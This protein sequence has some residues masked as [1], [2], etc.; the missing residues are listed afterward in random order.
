MERPIEKGLNLSRNIDR[1]LY[2]TMA[3][4]QSEARKRR[5]AG[6]DVLDLS[7]DEPV[8]E[9]PRLIVDAGL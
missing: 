4:I 3:V 6:E 2:P 5:A 1:L 9:A 7:F 8:T